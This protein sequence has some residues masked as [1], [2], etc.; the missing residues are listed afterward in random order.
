MVKPRVHLDPASLGRMEKLR[1]PLEDQVTSALHLAMDKVDESYHGEDV[2]QV[3][4]ELIEQTKAGLHPEVAAA[5]APDEQH[6][7]SVAATI[8]EGNA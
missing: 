1:E 6:L 5:I 8:V 4:D 3:T 7:R 2:E